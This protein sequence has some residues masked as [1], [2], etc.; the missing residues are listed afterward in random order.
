LARNARGSNEFLMRS[1]AM[2]WPMEG[3]RRSYYTPPPFQIE[4]QNGAKWGGSQE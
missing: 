1:I 4:R 2:S 3:A